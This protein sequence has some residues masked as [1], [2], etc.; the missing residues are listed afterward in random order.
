[1]IKKIVRLDSYLFIEPY[2]LHRLSL[3]RK[4]AL[5]FSCSVPNGLKVDVRECIFI[6]NDKE[7][8]R[9]GQVYIRFIKY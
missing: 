2:G 5:L 1:M 9:D 7:E 3:D 8:K 4:G 6:T